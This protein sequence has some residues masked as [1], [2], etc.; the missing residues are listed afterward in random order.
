MIRRPSDPVSSC[1]LAPFASFWTSQESTCAVLQGLSLRRKHASW[2]FEEEFLAALGAPLLPSVA[3]SFFCIPGTKFPKWLFLILRRPKINTL[4]SAFRGSCVVE[5]SRRHGY[6]RRTKIRHLV[7]CSP[8]PSNIEIIL[9]PRP[10][11]GR[12][13]MQYS[14]YSKKKDPA[15][16]IT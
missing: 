2:G 11:Q 8:R 1:V 13:L 6:S 14:K 10:R 5:V 15:F 3:T 12:K 4:F 16:T 7:L 9:E